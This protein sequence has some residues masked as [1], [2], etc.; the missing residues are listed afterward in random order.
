MAERDQRRARKHNNAQGL[1]WLRNSVRDLKHQ[2]P[3]DHAVEKILKGIEAQ[4]EVAWELVEQDFDEANDKA[5]YWRL[6][7][8]DDSDARDT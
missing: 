3:I 2:Y 4:I 8:L 5:E 7:T 6:A 1:M